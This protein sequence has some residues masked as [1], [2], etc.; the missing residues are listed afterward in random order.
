MD[1]FCLFSSHNCLYQGDFPIMKSWGL[2]WHRQYDNQP[3]FDSWEGVKIAI[4]WLWEVSDS[5]DTSLWRYGGLDPK[6]INTTCN[7]EADIADI[8]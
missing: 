7:T 2:P 3:Q 8:T 5:Y 6:I 4:F 1:K